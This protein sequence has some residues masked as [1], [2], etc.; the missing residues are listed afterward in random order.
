MVLLHI[1]SPLSS[2][3]I[4]PTVPRFMTL[5]LFCFAQFNQGHFHEHWMVGS[6][7]DKQLKAMTSPHQ[8]FPSPAVRGRAS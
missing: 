3:P 2:I 1:S 7:V 5:I 6:S 4:S 8:S